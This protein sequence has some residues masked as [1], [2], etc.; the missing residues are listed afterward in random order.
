MWNSSIDEWNYEDF[1]KESVKNV[2]LN[3]ITNIS[4]KNFGNI[5]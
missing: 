4:L 5:C 3:K 2:S 1:L